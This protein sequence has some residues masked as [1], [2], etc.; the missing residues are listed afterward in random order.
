VRLESGF[1]NALNDVLD[2]LFGRAVRHIHNHDNHL[3]G[4]DALY[5]QKWA[6]GG[7]VEFMCGDGAL[8]RQD[9]PEAPSPHN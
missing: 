4:R 5:P 6:E 3:S 2:L 1:A 7:V 8:P 9:R